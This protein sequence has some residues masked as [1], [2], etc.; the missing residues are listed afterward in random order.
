M[1]ELKERLTRSKGVLDQALQQKVAA[2]VQMRIT[3]I[4]KLN[5]TVKTMTHLQSRVLDDELI[6]WKREQ[7]LAGNGAHFISNLD[8]IQEW[9]ENLAEIIWLNRQQV[10]ELEK[11]KQNI[12]LEPQGTLDILSGLTNHVTQLLSSLVTR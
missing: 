6:R 11:L 4:D 7:Q 9:C 12:R 10:K 2:I 1:I 3:L 8:T 5:D